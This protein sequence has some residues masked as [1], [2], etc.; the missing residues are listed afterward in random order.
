MTA[1]L[2]LS[3][4][5]L[6]EDGRAFDR[7]RVYLVGALSRRAAVVLTLRANGGDLT[8]EG[9]PDPGA[10]RVDGNWR[11]PGIDPAGIDDPGARVMLPLL[12][13]PTAIRLAPVDMISLGHPHRPVA[14]LFARCLLYAGL[15][16]GSISWRVTPIVAP[17]M[18]RD[19]LHRYYFILRS[20]LPDT[21]LT[22][23]PPPEGLDLLLANLYSAALPLN[24][25]ML[26][27]GARA[28]RDRHV[29]D[30]PT[31]RRNF[32]LAR[33]CMLAALGA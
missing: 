30:L 23:R 5:D 13:L 11:A 1:T 33:A 9:A 25:A 6:F 3:T 28:L 22:S 31:L 10:S 7:V 19:L 8:L 18:S 12:F 15:R 27:S 20:C 32:E 17:A 29:G 24:N 21:A 16:N 4:A 26:K 14:D 2:S